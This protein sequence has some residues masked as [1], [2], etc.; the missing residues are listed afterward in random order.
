MF[1]LRIFGHMVAVILLVF[2][3]SGGASAAEQKLKSECALQFEK[4]L[5]KYNDDFGDQI[6]QRAACVPV[7]SGKFA[8]CDAGVAYDKARPWIEDQ[9]KKLKTFLIN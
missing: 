4:Y 5:K 1:L 7:C 6:A 8:T 3:L 2:G 9:A